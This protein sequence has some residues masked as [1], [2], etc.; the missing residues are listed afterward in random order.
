M[1]GMKKK[2][3]GGEAGDLYKN[4]GLGGR[5]K[6]KKGTPSIRWHIN[7]WPSFLFLFFDQTLDGVSGGG[8]WL[9]VF[10]GLEE[11]DGAEWGGRILWIGHAS[12]VAKMVEG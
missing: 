9:G 10:S 3:G 1:R 6:E 8:D 12:A 7:G 5:S 4:L 11:T 2:G